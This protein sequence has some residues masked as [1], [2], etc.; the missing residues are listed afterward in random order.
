[1][2]QLLA[3]KELSVETGLTEHQIRRAI[4]RHGLPKVRLGR[5]I[6]IPRGSFEHWL[7]AKEK[8]SIIIEPRVEVFSELKSRDSP[9]SRTMSRIN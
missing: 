3:I 9:I 8:S 5:R 4:S 1:M 6:F 2:T 7:D